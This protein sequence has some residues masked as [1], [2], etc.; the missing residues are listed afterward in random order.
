MICSVSGYMYNLILFVLSPHHSLIN[1]ET[2]SSRR[3]WTLPARSTPP[4]EG[5]LHSLSLPCRR[6]A[7]QLSIMPPLDV[8][9]PIR[10]LPRFHLLVHLH[11]LR[12]HRPH[13][14]PRPPRHLQHLP[15]RL[16]R[17]RPV[18][19]LLHLCHFLPLPF[20]IRAPLRPP[21]IP[22]P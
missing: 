15:A 11:H 16:R 3:R 21:S 7:P 14:L 6:R 1:G 4:Q 19:P 13:R 20:R 8:R 9:R 12:R 17:R 18:L 5:R 10:S 2:S 22:L